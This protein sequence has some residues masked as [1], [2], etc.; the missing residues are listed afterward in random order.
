MD[1]AEALATKPDEKLYVY[2]LRGSLYD[3]QKMY[4][5]AEASSARRWPSIPQNP[6]MLNYLGY[7]LADRGVKL[8]EA[9][10]MIRKAVELDPQNY[11]YPRL[12]GMGVLQDRSVC[13]G[14]REPAQ[15]E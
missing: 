9:L 6:T 4:D 1:T 14:G 15:G 13:P 8:P 7:M 2:F 11:A 5:E 10:T 12:A 3:R